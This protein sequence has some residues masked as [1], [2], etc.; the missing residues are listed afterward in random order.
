MQDFHE[1]MTGSR[2]IEAIEDVG[3]DTKE[4]I[5]IILK[6]KSLFNEIFYSTIQMTVLLTVGYAC[7][8]I[9]KHD[10]FF[11]NLFLYEIN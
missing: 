7:Y 1:L 4:A 5:Q 2:Q 3:E 11:Q 9:Y 8:E 6:S 10:L